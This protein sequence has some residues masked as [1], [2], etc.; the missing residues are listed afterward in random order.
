MQ[1]SHAET[2]DP[3][4][5]KAGRQEFEHVSRRLTNSSNAPLPDEQASA[6][7]RANGGDQFPPAAFA[8]TGG[9]RHG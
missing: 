6:F 3:R 5:R 4:D 1:A 8:V 9:R 2:P 7:I